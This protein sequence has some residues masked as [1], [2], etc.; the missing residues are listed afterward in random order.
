MEQLF[1]QLNID[2]FMAKP[3]EIE[4]LIS[5]VE[6]IIEKRSDAG[7]KVTPSGSR[8]PRRVCLVENKPELLNKIG[9]LFLA[10][11][12][13]VIPAQNGTEGIERIAGTVP[14][15]ALVSLGLTD[16]ARKI[17]EK[18]GVDRF[19]KF[20]SAQELLRAAHE[21]LNG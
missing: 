8:E 4:G 14:D 12:Y 2:G 20:V 6:T 3:F 19:I 16:I 17:G 9:S 21:V 13:M 7:V 15:V 1:K 10:A 11:G 18:E 5:E